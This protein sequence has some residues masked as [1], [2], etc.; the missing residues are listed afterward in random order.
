MQAT[1]QRIIIINRGVIVA[2]DTI[3]GLSQR[4]SGGYRV[5][6]KVRRHSDKLI[7][8]IK[9]LE[10]VVGVKNDGGYLQINTQQGDEI[11]EKLSAHIVAEGA[12][13]TEFHPVHESLEEIFIKLT[14]ENAKGVTV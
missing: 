10:G 13:L 6:V 4:M 1:C 11:F 7:D 2:E 5:K 3:A 14:S 9:R 12:G 8:S